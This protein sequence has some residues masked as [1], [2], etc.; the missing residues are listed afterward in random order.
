[1]PSTNT[2][3]TGL[4][5]E[6]LAQRL[7]HIL[8]LLHQGDAINKHELAHRF[9][10]DVRTI[11]RDLCKRLLGI[12]ERNGDGL[13]QLAQAARSTIPARDGLHNTG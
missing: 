13:W 9:G 5:G 7:T 10:V 1:M 4:K 11:E 8:A 12:A 3:L 2:P 6:K